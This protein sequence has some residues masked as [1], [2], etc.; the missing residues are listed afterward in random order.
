M[1]YCSKCG[2]ELF[3]EAVVC[4]NCGCALQAADAKGKKE[5]VAFNSFLPLNIVNFLFSILAISAMLFMMISII[6]P[7]IYTY[8]DY[9]SYSDSI[10]FYADSYFFPLFGWAITAFIIS[11]VAMVMGFISV[12]TSIVGVIMKKIG[13]NYVFSSFTRLFLSAALFTITLLMMINGW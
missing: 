9:Y 2:R 5:K 3:E 6:F 12:I 4:P 7:Y 13:S 10:Y 8:V 1:K 11:C